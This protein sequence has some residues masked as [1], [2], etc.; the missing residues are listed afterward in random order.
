MLSLGRVLVGMELDLPTLGGVVVGVTTDLH[1]RVV[2][3]AGAELLSLGGVERVSVRL[4][5]VRISQM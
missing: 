2:A 3:G 4:L 5:A 1:G